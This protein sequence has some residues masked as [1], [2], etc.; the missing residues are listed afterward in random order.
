MTPPPLFPFHDPTEAIEALIEGTYWPRLEAA[1]AA[2]RAAVM[3]LRA[4]NEA[5]ATRRGYSWA[6]HEAAV[7]AKAEAQH[8]LCEAAME[9]P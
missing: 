3:E 1:A 6:R 7:R 5:H 9:V 4:V 8:A 2:Y